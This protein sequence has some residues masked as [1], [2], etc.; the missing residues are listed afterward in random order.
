MNSIFE[1]LSGEKKQAILDACMEEFAIKG[2]ERASTNSIVK[3]AGISKGAL[4]NYF[5][6]KKKLFLYIFDFSMK[7]LVSVFEE[8]KAACPSDL[9]ERFVWYSMLKMKTYLKEPTMSR[10]VVSAVTNM[11][12]MLKKDLMTR[13]EKLY[14]KYIPGIFEGVDTSSFREGIDPQKVFELVSIFMQG[15][16]D[17]YLR[18]YK[19]CSVDEILGHI[20]KIVEEYHE[21][22]EM[23]KYG[24]YKLPEHINNHQTKLI[25]RE[26]AVC[27]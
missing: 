22:L 18:S 9:F 12:E 19:D 24:I 27:E 25:Q 15:I 3:K 5:G 14:G 8:S 26:D 11:P 2:Y 7:H 6:N 10:I 1:S 16:F 21:Y 23:F 13:I 4:F 20:D 17:K